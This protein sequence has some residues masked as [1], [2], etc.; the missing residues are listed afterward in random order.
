MTID[1]I[2]LPAEPISTATRRMLE[3]RMRAARQRW[4]RAAAAYRL[5]EQTM[6]DER[7]LFEMIGD[8]LRSGPGHVFSPAGIDRNRSF[9]PYCRHCRAWA[10]SVAGVQPCQGDTHSCRSPVELGKSGAAVKVPRRDGLL[11]GQRGQM[12]AD[13]TAWV[14]RLGH[15]TD[16]SHAES[17]I[18]HVMAPCAPITCPWPDLIGTQKG[19][20]RVYVG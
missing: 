19:W 14:C 9:L 16:G 4:E 7:R 12:N 2:V 5:A 20:T 1:E 11:C 8:L 13:F 18:R 17:G 15:V 3:A 10:S 6:H